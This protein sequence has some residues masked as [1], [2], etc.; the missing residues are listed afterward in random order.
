MHDILENWESVFFHIPI[1]GGNEQEFAGGQLPVEG[2]LQIVKSEG[3]HDH[4]R[5]IHS[6]NTLRKSLELL[7][8][9]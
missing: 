3:V 6:N 8:I 1:R 4:A 5:R 2:V 7:R 9:H